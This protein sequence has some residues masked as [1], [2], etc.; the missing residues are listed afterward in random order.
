MITLSGASAIIQAQRQLQAVDTA[1]STVLEDTALAYLDDLTERLKPLTPVVTGRMK[2][3]SSL[4]G[5]QGYYVQDYGNGQMELGDQMDYAGKVVDMPR[6]AAL[7]A[8]L[9]E[10]D[11]DLSASLSEAVTRRLAAIAG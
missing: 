6:H 11:D 2:G 9:S 3:V 1:L 10:A 4:S 8:L 5:P 7:L